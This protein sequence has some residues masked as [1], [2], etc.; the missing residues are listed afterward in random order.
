MDMDIDIDMDCDYAK[1]IDLLKMGDQYLSSCGI[2]E[3]RA[4]ADILL[5]DVRGISRDKLY[6][7]QDIEVSQEDKKH[8][9]EL[10]QR[11]GAREP[12][13]YLRKTREF[14]GLDFYVDENVLIPRPETELLVEKAVA[15]GK[16]RFQG[17]GAYILDLC[18]GSGA[19]AISMA[20]LWAQ[21][22]VSATDISKPALQ[23]AKQNA[24][25]QHVQVDFFQGDLFA[26]VFGKKFDM[27]VSNPP[28]VSPEEYAGCSPEVR[29]EPSLALLGGAD[30]LDFYKRI[31][32][33]AE[34]VLKPEG[35]ILLEI[36]YSQGL[37]VTELFRQSGYQTLIFPDYA[38]HD[39]IVIAEKE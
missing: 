36:G 5:A 13:A 33:Q 30:G 23:I 21:A 8:Y 27:I 10:L 20:S 12:L 17:Q 34:N 37:A 25:L 7:E 32:T 2:S 22:M 6:L 14:M 19:V 9:L 24:L 28:Y 26:P 31:A 35:I 1:T 4:E 29:R 11:R 3:A 16:D 15:I 18:T 38:G 39:R